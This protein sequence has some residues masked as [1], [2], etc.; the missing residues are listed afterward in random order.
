MQLIIDRFE[1]EFA[2][3]EYEVNNDIEFINLPKV[4]LEGASCGDVIDITINKNE[5]ARRENNI[6][7][8]MNDLFE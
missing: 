8:L 4:V 3:C 7:K 5:T 1:G 2:V 6:K